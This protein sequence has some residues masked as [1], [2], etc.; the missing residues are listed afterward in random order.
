MW[1]LGLWACVASGSELGDGSGLVLLE[2]EAGSVDVVFVGGA[3]GLGVAGPWFPSSQVAGEPCW[4]KTR[5]VLGA[6]GKRVE[7]GGNVEFGVEAGR[8][9]ACGCAEGGGG[10]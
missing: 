6:E 2:C 10:R 3:H 7:V 9:P 4:E 1:A 5:A 8:P